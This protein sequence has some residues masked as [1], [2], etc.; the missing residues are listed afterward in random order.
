MKKIIFSI[1][2]FSVSVYAYDYVRWHKREK[3]PSKEY[4]PGKTFEQVQKEYMD[5]EKKGTLEPFEKLIYIGEVD[6]FYYDPD[7]MDVAAGQGEYSKYR[8]KYWCPR[9][10]CQFY[11][12]M[13]V[14]SAMDKRI[15]KKLDKKTTEAFK[16]MYPYLSDFYKAFYFNAAV[17]YNQVEI[18][19]SYIE[20]GFDP[21]EELEGTVITTSTSISMDESS[22]DGVPERLKTSEL[23]VRGIKPIDV[24]IEYGYTEM[25]QVLRDSGK[26]R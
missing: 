19:R 4:K 6:R 15:T 3:Y 22:P 17:Q 21:N 9:T 2:L 1:L 18:V 7:E 11:V 25:I 16:G 14:T 8:G 23:I 5:A 24:A 26:L 13:Q 20:Q 10:T 12:D